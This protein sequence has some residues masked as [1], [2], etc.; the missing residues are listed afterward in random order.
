ALSGWSPLKDEIRS[1]A[2]LR[3]LLHIPAD[4]ELVSYSDPRTG[5]FRYAGF[6]GSRL[7]AGAFFG[8]PGKDFAGGEQARR[9][10]GKDVTAAERMALL[11]GIDAGGAAPAGRII[12]AC[13]SVSETTIADAIRDR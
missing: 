7:V 3:R 11:A 1:E 2:M 9:L 4:A 12:C 6:L 13:F 5:L 8:P 10:L